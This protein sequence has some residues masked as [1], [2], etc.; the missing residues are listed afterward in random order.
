M[1]PVTVTNH[2]KKRMRERC[3]IQGISEK[4]AKRAYKEGLVHAEAPE[5]TK[6]W[7]SYLY[8]RHRTVNNIRIW[9]NRAWLF[10]SS[11]L[12]TVIPLPEYVEKELSEKYPQNK[13]KSVPGQC[14]T[15]KN[16]VPGTVYSEKDTS[17]LYLGHVRMPWSVKNG[18]GERYYDTCFLRIHYTKQLEQCLSCAYN[19]DAVMR[20]LDTY[21]WKNGT[22]LKDHLHYSRSCFKFDRKEKKVATTSLCGSFHL[23]AKNNILPFFPGQDL[24]LTWLKEP[25]SDLPIINRIYI[26]KR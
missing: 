23:S 22:I 10:A 26:D 5:R 17:Y 16:L 2:A 7:I 11:T 8:F 24:E 13:E 1:K 4:M 6:K 3:G 21:V 20:T 25:I 12:V 19:M 9:H 14:L 15:E 18:I